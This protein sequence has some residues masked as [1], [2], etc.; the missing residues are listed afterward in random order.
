[1]GRN[2]NSFSYT[3]DERFILMAV[4]RKYIPCGPN[5]WKKV[6]KEYNETLTEK[7]FPERHRTHDSLKVQWTKLNE[8]KKPTG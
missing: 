7:G 3:D 4:M 5:Q 6:E 2:K 1:M 8:M